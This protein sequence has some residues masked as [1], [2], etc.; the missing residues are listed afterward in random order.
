LAGNVLPA[1]DYVY[2][3]S[4]SAHSA[5]IPFTINPFERG[6]LSVAITDG[7]GER[8]IGATSGGGDAPLLKGPVQ[9]VE[10]DFGRRFTAP[11]LEHVLDIGLIFNGFF[12]YF[13]LDSLTVKPDSTGIVYDGF[14][15]SRPWPDIAGEGSLFGYGLFS[16]HVSLF[17]LGYNHEGFTWRD[18]FCQSSGPE[19]PNDW[20]V[21]PGPFYT[22]PSGTIEPPCDNP[23]LADQIAEIRFFLTEP[24]AV[25]IYLINSDG[26]RVRRL[27][28]GDFSAGFYTIFWDRLDDAGVEVPEG[29]YH[30]IWPGHDVDRLAVVASGDIMISAAMSAVPDVAANPAA[31]TLSANHPNPFNPRTLIGITLPAP[32]Y[33]R[34]TILSLDGKR[35]T[36]LVEGQL[37]A[38]EYSVIWDGR[39]FR[40]RPVPS[41]TYFYRLEAD[42]VALTRP[43][44][45]LK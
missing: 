42:G 37:E 12:D 9:R 36:T 23:V 11:E 16:P 14:D 8:V 1:G 29:L 34:L 18:Q 26:D 6:S 41:G 45:L 27:V 39:D 5:E 17:R 28:D 40:G 15:L 24:G 10:I 30:L 4:S 38:G 21:N 13:Q 32:G 3:V 22:T 43:M 20:I 44:V 31:P 35:V 7:D 19:D 33:A 2:R 25:C